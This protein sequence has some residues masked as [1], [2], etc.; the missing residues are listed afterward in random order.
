MVRHTDADGSTE[1]VNDAT[2]F[3]HTSINGRKRVAEHDV[4][5]DASDHHTA[6]NFDDA[7]MYVGDEPV[8]AVVRFTVDADAAAYEVFDAVDELADDGWE[9]ERV[10]TRASFTA[11]VDTSGA[12]DQPAGS[13][14][15]D[16]AAKNHRTEFVARKRVDDN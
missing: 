10:S 13:P 2:R 3:V 5:D 14:P 7:G 1:D 6:D 12:F 16:E 11:P 9:V 4:V 8:F 15:E